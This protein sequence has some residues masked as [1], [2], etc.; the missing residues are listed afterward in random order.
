MSVPRRCHY[1]DRVDGRFALAAYLPPEPGRARRYVGWVCACC[2]TVERAAHFAV[3]M[4][5]R[6]GLVRLVMAPGPRV[7]V[8]DLPAGPPAADGAGA[9]DP[10]RP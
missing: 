3:A 7:W 4:Q 8:A 10:A 6:H 2:A 9:R 1:C 5:R